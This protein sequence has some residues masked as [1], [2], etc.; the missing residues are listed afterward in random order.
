MWTLVETQW[1]ETVDAIAARWPETGPEDLV[2]INGDHTRFVTYLAQVHDLT[3][4]EAD[5]AVEDW[6]ALRFPGTV[7][8]G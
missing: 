8:P 3:L 2:A 5:E 1:H 4:R 7:S 6:L